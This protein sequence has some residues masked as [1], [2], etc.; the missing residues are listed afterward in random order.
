[1]DPD[2]E[3][4]KA[5]KTIGIFI[6]IPFVLAVPPIIGWFLGKW[7]DKQT[8]TSPYIMYVMIFLGF[9]SG[10]RELYRILKRYSNG[11]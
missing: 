1:M 6:T 3:H 11:T 8:G 7:I 4:Q 9:V 10:Y 2:K 5:L